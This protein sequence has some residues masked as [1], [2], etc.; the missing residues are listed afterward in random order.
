MVD[1]GVF[2]AKAFNDPEKWNHQAVGIAGDELTIQQL[3]QSFSKA[4]GK[5]APQ[6]YWFLGS[7]LTTMVTELKLMLGW[8]ASDGYKAN[9]KERR[10][11]HPGML[12]M[13]RWLVERS[14]F[15]TG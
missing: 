3:N 6:A 5:P 14:G 9:I 2:A 11:E 1:V 4:T 15:K 10:K 7:A 12:C 13:E 8:F